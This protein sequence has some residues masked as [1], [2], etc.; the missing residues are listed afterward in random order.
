MVSLPT[1]QHGELYQ[2]LANYVYDDMA[3]AFI[4]ESVM[5]GIIVQ[6]LQNKCPGLTS[7]TGMASLP[8][9]FFIYYAM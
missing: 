1:K 8:G 9:I 7:Y 3:P 2:A 6:N 5:F 4:L